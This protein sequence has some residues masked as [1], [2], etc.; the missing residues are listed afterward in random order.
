MDTTVV[1]SIITSPVINLGNDTIICQNDS[2]V[3]DPGS[4]FASYFWQDGNTAQTRT[5]KTSGSFWVFVTDNN[6][7]TST[8]SIN[9]TLSPSYSIIYN[10]TICQGD[11]L[12][13]GNIYQNFSGIYYDTLNSIYTCDSVII[14]NLL[15]LQI[16]TTFIYDTI[17]QGDSILA[18]GDF[19]NTEGIYYDTLQG[20]Y[21]CDS[22][23][24]TDLTIIPVQFTYVY[25]TIC[26]SDSIFAGGT[27]Q[28]T[29]GVYFDTLSGI[30]TCDSIIVTNLT[31]SPIY[32]TILDITICFGDSVLAGG[33][34]QNSP[35]SYYDTITSLLACD[36]IIITN[37][38][39]A[40][41]Y[42]LLVFD[43][44]CQNDSVFVAGDYQNTQGIYYDSLLSIIGCD[45][46]RTTF[47][48]VLPLSSI[49]LYDT[50]CE[51]DSVFTGGTY[52]KSAGIY[53]DTLFGVYTCDSIVITELT[54]L[55]TSY[56]TLYDSVCYGDSLFVGGAY[57]TTTGLFYDTLFNTF[58]CDSIIITDLTV[59]P[60]LIVDAGLPIIIGSASS[61]SLNAI[62]TGGSGQY[63][64]AWTP[65]A[66][67]NNPNIPNPIT[68][69]LFSS[70]I[71]NLTVQDTI[72]GCI[73]TSQVIVTVLSNPL[74]INSF[75]ATSTNLC[76]G[77]SS[78]LNIIV[79]GGTGNYN[80]SWA[81]DPAGFISNIPNPVVT[82]TVTT[83]YSVTVSDGVF[84]LDSNITINV[85]T[86]PYVNV[87]KDT[88]VCKGDYV[89]LSAN[90]SPNVSY[91]WN[92]TP[93]QNTQQI[94]VN[95]NTTTL[96]KVLVS[97]IY[98][99]IATDSA[100]VT[101]FPNP[102]AVITPLGPT[103]ICIGDSV[104]LSTNTGIGYTYNWFHNSVI[105]PGVHSF[106]YSA[107]QSGT[108]SV[109]LTNNS[110]CTDTSAS[111]T[112][113]TSPVPNPQLGGDTTICFYDTL[114][115]NPGIGFSS[116]LWS[117]GSTNNALVVT[118]SI[119]NLG[120]KPYSVTV[121][122]NGCAAWDS[123]IVTF[124]ACTGFEENSEKNS[125]SLFPNPNNGQFT[126]KFENDFA[127]NFVLKVFN[128]LGVQ[129]KNEKLNKSGKLFNKEMDVTTLPPGI[130]LLSIEFE[131]RKLE[132]MFVVK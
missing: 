3:L 125:I 116:Y 82:P 87:E 65:A 108:Y 104:L 74:V 25:D 113:I 117:N 131:N 23:I 92:T 84:T 55:L 122:D 33:G 47:L 94:I 120:P 1:I 89:I 71:F 53:Y 81:S 77:D 107:L 100:T 59:I 111:L 80:Y 16:N 24:I 20:F 90:S 40:P 64:Y 54:V 86:I 93:V 8:D 27:Y 30:A 105:I 37:L 5:V 29:A 106:V 99:C 2:L 46:I 49:I 43:S 10:D 129:V 126:M 14:T 102:V 83:I 19:Q 91:S 70:V 15:V 36:S 85:G 121:T 109:V 114:I 9:I 6:G 110:G 42:S 13:I 39:I 76:L 124:D 130:Y 62:V 56:L 128:T 66:L 44:I 18:G 17:C 4:G 48:T 51:G 22:I 50:I 98:G 97:N 58:G 32:N 31:V 103:A 132:R 57:Q 41:P 63:S 115:L 127:G 34:Y 95:P 78:Q 26:Q 119:N 72:T 101:V 68:I 112:I 60:Q 35:G 88:V 28:D 69:T 38:T 75:N 73:G 21:S 52:K 67:L 96:Y 7:C 11:S 12:L 123:I 45:S 79:S 118:S 61:V